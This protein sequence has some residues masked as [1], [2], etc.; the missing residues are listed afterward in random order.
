MKIY[1]LL[2]IFLLFLNISCSKEDDS[3]D[4]T[5]EISQEYLLQALQSD[6]SIL[7]IEQTPNSLKIVFNDNSVITCMRRKDMFYTTIGNGKNWFINGVNTNIK[8]VS[9]IINYESELQSIDV[10]TKGNWS[11]NGIDTNVRADMPL[12]A[13]EVPFVK[14]IVQS[15][16]FF[17]FYFTDKTILRF[18]N[19]RE[20]NQTNHNKML[21]PIHPKSLKILCIGNSFTDD[22]TNRLPKIIQSA[23]LNDIYIGHLIAGNASLKQYYDSYM[24]NISIGTYQVTNDQMKWK[25]ISEN[26]T[27]KQALQYED[28]DIITF[29]QVS[30]EAGR[31]QSY[32]PVLSSLIDVAKYEC[33]NS[34]PVIACQIPW[35]YGTGCKEKGFGKYEYNQLKMYKSIIDA[36][37]VIVKQSNIDIIIPVGTAIQN[38]RNTNLNNPPLDITRDY[39]HLDQGI[40]RY[41]ASCTLFQALISPIYNVKLFDTSF[42]ELYGNVPVTEKNFRI[43]QQAAINACNAPFYITTS[44]D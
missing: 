20:S 8:T 42:F 16:H 41:T 40:G 30:H 36:T 15:T 34:K 38:L 35:A 32:E 23:G 4:D 5:V 1:F 37:R 14:N 22:A 24:K 31:L 21:L 17:Y 28:W 10:D 43:C 27:L 2:T 25:T 11:I 44:T 7:E 29:Q 6:L 9:N 33:R 26:Y 39:R 19:Q 3:N 13:P 18:V 12:N